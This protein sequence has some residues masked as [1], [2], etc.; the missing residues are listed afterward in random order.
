VGLRVPVSAFTALSVAAC[1]TSVPDRH[2]TPDDPTQ[3]IVLGSRPLTRPDTDTATDPTLQPPQP[4]NVLLVLLDDVGAEVL[5]PASPSRPTT[6]EIDSLAENGVRFEHSWGAP[7]CSQA[8]AALMTGRYTHRFGLGWVL[9]LHSAWTM[10]DSE[11]LI[12]E[13]LATAGLTSLAL[14]KWH[15][16]VQI[17]GEAAWPKVDGFTHYSLNAGTLGPGFSVSGRKM[18]YSKWEEYQPG[19]FSLEQGYNTEAIGDRAQA[20]IASMPEPWFTYLAFN[21][22]HEPMHV[23]PS[24]LRRSGR[25]PTLTDTEQKFYWMI[26]AVDSVLEDL[27]DGMD[28]AVR[29]RTLVIVSAD[30]GSEPKTVDPEFVDRAKGSVYEHGV[31][32][33]LIISGPGVVNPG[34]TSDAHVNLVDLYPTIAEVMGATVTTDI[35]GVSLVPLLEDRVASVRT[36]DMVSKFGASGCDWRRAIRD[37]RYKW[38]GAWTAG[39]P[40]EEELYDLQSDPDERNDLFASGLSAD[41]A[42]HAAALAVELADLVGVESPCKHDLMDTGAPN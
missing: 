31:T 32:V 18:S 37:E 39:Y 16:G 19:V 2:S 36:Y 12:P 1:S 33:P 34:R 30:N 10:P 22:P 26:E 7:A 23:P 29:A 9:S 20:E 41:A 24:V 21:A 13:M 15:L 17:D 28:P 42:A 40:I 14:G 3:P 38:V 5:D 11:V 25:D 27:L 6:P 8:R 4:V 35:D